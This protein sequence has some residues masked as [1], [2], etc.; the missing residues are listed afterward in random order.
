MNTHRFSIGITTALLAASLVTSARADLSPPGQA[1][2]T[3]PVQNESA[4]SY[5]GQLRKN[6]APVNANCNASFGLF[7]SATGGAQIGGTV[8]SP[9][10]RVANGLFTIPL[11]F[12]STF[13]GEARWL[14][15]SVGCGETQAT[16]I[17]RTALR[18]APYAFALPGLYTRPNLTSPNIV[19]GHS[20]NS[21]SSTVYGSVI[22][23]GGW[24]GSPNTVLESLA[25]IAGGGGN[26]ASG[27]AAAIGGGSGNNAGG[28]AAT[29]GGGQINTSDGLFATIA[30]GNGNIAS[31]GA[32]FVGGGGN[33]TASGAFASIGG[34]SG[35]TASGVGATIPGGASNVAV[36]N[37]LAA[38]LQAKAMHPGAFVWADATY[39]DFASTAPNQFLIRAAGRVGISGY[40]GSIAPTAQLHVESNDLNVLALKSTNTVGTWANLNNTAAGGKTWSLVSS[41]PGNG[42][43]A[44]KFLIYDGNTT[45][46]ALTSGNQKILMSDGANETSGV[47]T[48][49]SDRNLKANF[50]PV[51]GQAVLAQIASL[52]LSSWNYKSD[53]PAIRHIGPMAQDFYTA[54]N[55][56][57]DNTH[58]GTV[59]TAGVALAA[60][61][62]LDQENKE[63]RARNTALEERMTAL[64]QRAQPAAPIDSVLL[65]TIL[66]AV[67]GLTLFVVSRAM[68]RA[69]L[70]HNRP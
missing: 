11:D 1:S 37:T 5:Q 20:N 3:L 57:N 30:G 28:V 12:G 38:G 34:G 64:E 7:D 25:T 62:A 8:T 24:G 54:F 35:N 51:D 23:G 26:T 42:E 63:L 46:M 10:L 60:I 36:T 47:W 19:G 16:L 29:I 59:D 49:S 66:A 68:G 14:E 4:F 22:G 17:P 45:I 67:L 6:G 15:T 65:G 52:P 69:G 53:D 56:G 48:N 33:N 27:L 41:G 9:T 40:A 21:I 58:I 44:G 39:A 43:G 32:S 50:A 2:P 13:N 55:V 61:Q 70:N 18:P 31:G